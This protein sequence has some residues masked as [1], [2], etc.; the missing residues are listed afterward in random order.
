[1]TNNQNNYSELEQNVTFKSG[2][3]FTFNDNGHDFEV[4]GSAWSGKEE[5][6]VDGQLVAKKLSF[7][8]RSVMAFEMNGTQ[9][10]VEFYMANMRTGELHCSL[11]KEGV[12]VKTSK[13]ALTPV[14][15]INGKTLPIITF[16][17]FVLGGV[18]GYLVTSLL[19]KLFG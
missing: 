19:F 5:V 9:Y 8:R 17:G 15:Q 10:E 1:M 11:I 12:H 16:F 7:K 2:Y 3:V 13:K 18:A 4:R 6:Y 14:N